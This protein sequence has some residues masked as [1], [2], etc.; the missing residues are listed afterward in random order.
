VTTADVE[1]PDLTRPIQALAAEPAIA[2]PPAPSP[3]ASPAAPVPVALPDADEFETVMPRPSAG[4]EI[5]YVPLAV[6]VGD[7]FKFGC[8]FFMAFV[9]A[10]LLGF[11]MLSALFALGSLMGVGPFLSP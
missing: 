4:G 10:M 11:V 9:V 5:L 2:T 7:G 6:S 3:S 1:D 8:G